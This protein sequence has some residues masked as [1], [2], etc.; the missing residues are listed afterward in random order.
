MDVRRS[1]GSPV[2]MLTALAHVEAA[3]NVEDLAGDVGGFV[4]GEEHDGG[5]D[6]GFGAEAR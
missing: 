4:A 3:V 1:D 2:E 6:V 5:C